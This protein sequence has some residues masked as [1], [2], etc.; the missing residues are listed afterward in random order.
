MP[1]RNPSIDLLSSDDA[2]AYLS[3][4]FD[5]PERLAA[6][7]MGVSYT[8]LKKFTKR[9]WKDE[10][11]FAKIRAAT[12]GITLEAVEAQ[13]LDFMARCT[14]AEV[15]RRMARANEHGWLQKRMRDPTPQR[16]PI[17]S[18]PGQSALNK[19]QAKQ[20]APIAKQA[21]LPEPIPQQAIEHDTVLQQDLLPEPDQASFALQPYHMAV[22]P[23]NAY[24]HSS[25]FIIQPEG[26]STEPCQLDA[27]PSAEDVASWFD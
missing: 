1:T 9:V 23:N 19:K 10:W 27:F 21:S 18:Q 26:Y 12:C 3:S 4:F 20:S 16:V 11:P 5:A 24:V 25:E 7:F 17:T 15:L 2:F 6:N 22:I 14:D 8:T 13:R